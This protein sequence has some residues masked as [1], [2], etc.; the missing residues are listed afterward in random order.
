MRMTR[1]GPAGLPIRHPYSRVPATLIFAGLEGAIR[2]GV[3]V[4]Q[5][6]FELIAHWASAN[7]AALMDDQ[8][9]FRRARLASSRLVQAVRSE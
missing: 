1:A 6:A 9:Q 2:R 3:E 8:K 4:D 7:V 5:V